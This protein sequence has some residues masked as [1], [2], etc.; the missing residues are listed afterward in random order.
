[1]RYEKH[2]IF[3]HFLFFLQKSEPWNYFNSSWNVFDFIVV[4]GENEMKMR[5][6]RDD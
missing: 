4:A 5:E 3:S 1:M 2:N 6:M